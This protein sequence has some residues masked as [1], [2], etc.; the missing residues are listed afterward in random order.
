MWT[1]QSTNLLNNSAMAIVEKMVTRPGN[2]KL[3]LSRYFPIF[4]VPVWSKDTAANNVPYVGR[5]KIPFAA[6]YNAARVDAGNFSATPMGIRIATVAAWLKS[7]V[8]SRN[9]P[10]AKAIG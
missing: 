10:A 5:K 4:V 1:P 8:E 7:N 3:W 9:I 6:G 2:M